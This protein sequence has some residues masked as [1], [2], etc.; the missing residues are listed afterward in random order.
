MSIAQFAACAGLPRPTVSAILN[1]CTDRVKTATAARIR[2]VTPASVPTVGWVDATGSMRRLQALAYAGWPLK[3]IA[4][5]TGGID[6]GWLRQIRAGGTSGRVQHA[7]ARKIAGAYD[8]LLPITPPQD[9]RYQRVAV[10]R[11]RNLAAAEGWVSGW[12][13]DDIDDPA[14]VARGAIRRLRPR[15][16]APPSCPLEAPAAR[17][18]GKAR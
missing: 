7:I 9:T 13:W 8:R 10:T 14:D 15:M 12:A 18:E 4:I 5:E 1:D 6:V 3:L 17:T 2:A 11:A 16:Q